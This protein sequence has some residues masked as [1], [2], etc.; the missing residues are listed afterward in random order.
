MVRTANIVELKPETLRAFETYARQAEGEMET[1]LKGSGAFLW[2]DGSVVRT[3]AVREGSIVAEFWSGHSPVKVPSGLIHDWIGA[4]VV[5]GATVQETLT[6]V[7][8]YD[9]H[10]NIYQPE[11][12][13]SKLVSHHGNDFKIQLRLLKKKVITVVLDTDHDVRYLCVDRMRWFCRSHTTRIAE[14]EDA[15]TQ[16]ETVLPPDT[17]HGF[18]WRLYSY[19]RFQEKKGGVCIECRAVSLTRDIPFGLGWILEP[20]VQTLPR[21]SLINTLEATR[22]ALTQ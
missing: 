17:G 21:E 2:S 19:W 5:P 10:K 11:V 16:K 13:D 1:T 6:L 3:Q 8:D 4:A 7:Q 20:I 9:H 14:V 18:L 12:M 22:R 15:G